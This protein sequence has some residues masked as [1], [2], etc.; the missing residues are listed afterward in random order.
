[1]STRP[2]RTSATEK[3]LA[4]GASIADAAVL[5]DEGSQPMTD[6]H[7]DGTYRR[8]LARVLTRRSLE[9]ATR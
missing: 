8:H 5:A 9:A 7:A 3:A 1:M 2:I 4:E 6:M